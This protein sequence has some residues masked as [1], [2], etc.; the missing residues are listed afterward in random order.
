MR[1]A[2]GRDQAYFLTMEGAV[3]LLLTSEQGA[4]NCAAEEVINQ[5]DAAELR[6]AFMFVGHSRR[7]RYLRLYRVLDKVQCAT[8]P[9]SLRVAPHPDSTAHCLLVEMADDGSSRFDVS[10][11]SD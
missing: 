2:C 9:L 6:G 5:H 8:G 11:D 4:A 10:S 7:G 1:C 3:T